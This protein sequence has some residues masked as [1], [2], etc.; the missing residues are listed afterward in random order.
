MYTANQYIQE[1]R[2]FSHPS[3]EKKKKKKIIPQVFE[4]ID[5]FVYEQGIK[6]D[7][8]Q[9]MFCLLFMISGLVLCQM[10]FLTAWTWDQL[11]KVLECPL[12][13]ALKKCSIK[14]KCEINDSRPRKVSAFGHIVSPH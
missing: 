13:V 10:L 6:A 5:Q 11:T 9:S 2:L 14:Y 4:S 3:W 8:F 7:W 12:V 1:R